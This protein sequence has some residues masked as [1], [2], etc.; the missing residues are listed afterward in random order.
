[1]SVL[2]LGWVSGCR[3]KKQQTDRPVVAAG[4]RSRQRRSVRARPQVGFRCALDGAHHAAVEYRAGTP[5]PKSGESSRE[6]GEA[7]TSAAL[8]RA[9]LSRPCIIVKIGCKFAQ[10]VDDVRRGLANDEPCFVRETPVWV[11]VAT[12]RDGR[13]A[14]VH[15]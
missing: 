8:R 13:D 1:M 14:R 10:R 2:L 6:G 12:R 7:R 4:A 9:V 15:V 5:L 11:P 3:G